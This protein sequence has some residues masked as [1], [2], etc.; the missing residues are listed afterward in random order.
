MSTTEDHKEEQ[1][2]ELGYLVLPSIPEAD[3]S[4]VVSNIQKIIKKEGAKELDSEAPELI[5][6]AYTMSKVVGARKY[7]ADEAYIGWVKFESEPEIA[8]KVKTAVEAMQEVLRLLLVKAPRET[9]FTF[10]AARA[11]Q[12]EKDNPTPEAEVV[13]PVEEV[14]PVVE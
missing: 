5:D 13:A 10:A 14:A 4:A 7:L 3:L 1:V 6:L 8:P 9:T 12:A 2:Y 11:A